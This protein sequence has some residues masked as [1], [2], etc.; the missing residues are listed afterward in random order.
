MSKGKCHLEGNIWYTNVM[1]N[2]TYCIGTCWIC[3]CCN[4]YV[5]RGHSYKYALCDTCATLQG[6]WRDASYKDKY[7]KIYINTTKACKD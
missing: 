5:C 6:A 3:E 1:I 4:K 7:E 2:R